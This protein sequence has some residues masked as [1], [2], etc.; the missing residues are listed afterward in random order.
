MGIR[1]FLSR[2]SSSFST[3]PAPR[4]G[5]K[6]S[7]RVGT[8]RWAGVVAVVAGVV[9]VVAGSSLGGS[10]VA[11]APQAPGNRVVSLASPVGPRT[12]VVHRPTNLTR[13]APLVVVMHGAGG[14]AD[15]VRS[16]FGWD[17]LADRDGFEVA[18]PNG[19]NKYWNAGY[20]CGVPHA[21]DVDD[22]G[23]L[24]Q[25]VELLVTQDGVDPRRVY[26]VGMSNG[27]MM[28]YAWACARPQ[29]LAG[30]GPV[31][32]ALV[33]PCR[34]TPAITVVAVHGTA[35][36]S[37]PLAGG[38]GPRSVSH[39]PYPS[40]MQSLAPFVAAD[41][42][43]GAPRRSDQPPL[44]LSTWTCGGERSVTLAVISGLG[45]EWPGARASG[46]TSV[47]SHQPA[48]P[49]DATTFLWTHLRGSSLS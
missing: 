14:S 25:L 48:P 10:A 40:V 32:G 31:A 24:H 36:R 34:P 28:A 6:F 33:A 26:A 37:V 22:V 46:P 35:D 15:Q 21:R 43:V 13:N 18:Y 2:V 12:A 38:V 29:D 4:A 5:I 23:F 16:T 8:A 39:Y 20:C 47:L 19:F 3:P 30:I 17:G 11:A 42:C 44:R 7:M 41:H 45:H 27:A 1:A 9:A 49:L